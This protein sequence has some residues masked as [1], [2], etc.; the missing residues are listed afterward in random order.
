MFYKPIETYLLYFV[1]ELITSKSLL[2]SIFLTLSKIKEASWNLKGKNGQPQGPILYVEKTFLMM[3]SQTGGPQKIV[4][5][6]FSISNIF[7]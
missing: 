4:I 3:V 7:K 2:V 1:R 5:L 6:K